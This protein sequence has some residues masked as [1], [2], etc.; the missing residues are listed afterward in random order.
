M[1]SISGARKVIIISM[2]LKSTEQWQEFLRNYPRAHLLQTPEWGS[3]KQEYGW[4]VN[5]LQVDDLGAQILFQTLP[6]GFS[7]AYLPRGPVSSQPDFWKS[8]SW[9]RFLSELDSL[10]REHRAI[11]LKVEPDLWEG[12]SP[13]GE[14]PPDGFRMNAHSIQPPRTIVVSLKE[15][16]E[17][18]LGRMKSKTRYNI[19]LAGRKDVKV[20]K[21]EEIGSFYKL[22]EKTADRAEFGIHD[23]EYYRR[24]FDLLHP[25]GGCQIFVAEYEG[26][27]LASIMIFVR[28]NR[29]W[30]FY[31]ASSSQH[32]DRMPTYLVQWEAMRWAKTEGCES[33][34]LW[35]VPD[36]D[37]ETLEDQFLDRNEGLW[38]V[39]RFKRGFGG[40][41]KRTCG[42]WDRVYLPLFYQFYR[43]WA[44]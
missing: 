13:R 44:Q 3:L 19:R 28:G 1:I 7:A 24:V 14:N 26:Q 9:S 40:V 25:G 37:F 2:R 10:C 15:D 39:Y 31:G 5:W 35:G 22:L 30:Y 38:G 4:K 29:A 12:V 20:H 42:P 34:D 32:R 21:S 43:F 6:L 16:E 36:E 27:P 41:V 8:Q 11:F 23:R 17:E 33:Y 18:I